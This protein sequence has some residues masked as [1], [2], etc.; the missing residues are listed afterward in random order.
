[1]ASQIF[2]TKSPDHLMQ[3]AAAPERQ[4]KRTLGA[5]DLTCI[6]IGAII[7][8]GIF[9]LTGTAAAGQTFSSRLETPI[10]NFIQAWMSGSEVLLG[11]AGA[12]PA[13]AVSFVVAAIACAFAALCYAELASMIP[14][15]GS[16]YTYSY[17]TLGELV[18]WIIG[19]DLILEYAVGN[20]AVA[21]G[22]SGYF[23]QLCGSMFGLKFPIWLVNDHA[24]ATTLVAKGGEPLLGFSST[25]LPVIAGHTIAFNLP[26]LLI[27]AAVTVLLIYGIRES[28]R[29]NTAIVI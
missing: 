17:A 13:I 21:V 10:L 6:G 9:A 20:M 19:W 12:G 29:T 18:A 28:A 26:A 22:W 4:M 8:S 16:A 11:R 24:T 15:A 1:M 25:T 3:E 23:V 5:F 2:R 27:V 14:V 7:G